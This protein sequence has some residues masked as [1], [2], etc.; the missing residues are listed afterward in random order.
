MPCKGSTENYELET[1]A[2]AIATVSFA[3]IPA[4]P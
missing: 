2:I 1:C 3:E 4:V